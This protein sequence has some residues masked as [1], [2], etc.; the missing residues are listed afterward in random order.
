MMKEITTAELEKNFEDFLDRVNNGEKFLIDNKV[1]LTNCDDLE[2]LNDHYDACWF[3]N[4][5]DQTLSM[6]N[7]SFE[8]TF[9]KSLYILER[10]ANREI[11]LDYDYPKIYKKVKKFYENNGV[12]FYDEPEADY[13][14]ILALIAEELEIK[15]PA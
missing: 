15:V 8:T 5:V 9:R 3:I 7:K 14:A 11:D 4:T 2:Y 13:E 6:S 1:V 10:A 12:E